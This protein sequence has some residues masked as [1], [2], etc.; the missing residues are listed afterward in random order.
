MTKRVHIRSVFTKPLR[1]FT[2]SNLDN[3][4]QQGEVLMFTEL[5]ELL[6]E[7]EKDCIFELNLFSTR[8]I[9]SRDAKRKQESGNV[10][11]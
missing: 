2:Q 5:I 9:C 3:F 4:A 8:R 6:L 1:Y 7:K 10:I 11:G